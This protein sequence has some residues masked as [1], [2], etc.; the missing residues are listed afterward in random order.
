MSEEEKR[1]Y[2]IEAIKD[3]IEQNGSSSRKAKDIVDGILMPAVDQVASNYR[4]LERMYVHPRDI[5]S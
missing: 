3:I 4:I 1:L 2:L 5:G